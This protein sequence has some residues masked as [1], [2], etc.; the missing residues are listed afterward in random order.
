MNSLSQSL[1][2]LDVLKKES[3]LLQVEMNNLTYSMNLKR[4]RMETVE[5]ALYE[6]N[7]RLIQLKEIYRLAKL[8]FSR[9]RNSGSFAYSEELTDAD[10]E[11]LEKWIGRARSEQ[12]L[13][14]ILEAIQ[15][16]G[17]YR[18]RDIKTNLYALVQKIIIGG[19]WKRQQKSK[20]E[21]TGGSFDVMAE[22]EKIRKS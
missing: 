1:E 19:A 18:A 11:E 15:E 6:K 20:A 3:S 9:L 2:E 10:V 22:H 12:G 5:K 8:Q 7:I 4:S 17:K 21:T 16:L 14:D 13:V